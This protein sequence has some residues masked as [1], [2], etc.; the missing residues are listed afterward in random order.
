MSSSEASRERESPSFYKRLSSPTGPSR[1][2]QEMAKA[3]LG[4]KRRCLSCTAAFFD[5]NKSPILCPKCEAV[6]QVVEIAHSLPRRMPFRATAARP[7]PAEPTIADE[8]LPVVEDEALPVVEGESDER[9]GL[10]N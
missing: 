8:A 4:V 9:A 10:A 3:E 7:A 6:F 5:L 1:R 2:D